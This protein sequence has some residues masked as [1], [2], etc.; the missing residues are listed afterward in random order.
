GQLG[1]DEGR[2]RARRV[3][4]LE[5]P[6]RNLAGGHLVA[7]ALVDHRVDDLVRRVPELGKEGPRAEEDEARGG[8]CA[9]DPAIRRVEPQ[10]PRHELER[11]RENE[12]R[13]REHENELRVAQ[14]KRKRG[15]QQ[16]QRRKRAAQSAPPRVDGAYRESDDE[17]RHRKTPES[18]PCL[19][20][21]ADRLGREPHERDHA[22][23]RDGGDPGAAVHSMSNSSPMTGSTP[24]SS[25][26]PAMSGSSSPKEIRPNRSPTSFEIH[27]SPSGSSGRC[28]RSSASVVF[29]SAR[30]QIRIRAGT[31]SLSG[32]R[33]SFARTAFA[34]RSTSTSSWPKS[35]R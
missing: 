4:E 16:R 11:G 14:R 31:Y 1:R 30:F 24:I 26:T 7:V 32:G 23:D 2:E 15:E 13:E 33:G 6:V 19:A 20:V 10:H 18:L 5:V 21:D 17:R 29:E 12:H 35:S 34:C 25:T 8:G 22:D 27:A 3:L 9:E 28:W